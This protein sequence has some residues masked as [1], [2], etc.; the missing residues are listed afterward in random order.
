MVSES[1]LSRIPGRRKF[2]DC[3]PK[4]LGR[5]QVIGH[6][7][8][9][10]RRALSRSVAPRRTTRPLLLP[11]QSMRSTV[12]THLSPRRPVHSGGSK[13]D[14]QGQ[15]QPWHLTGH[16]RAAESLR[17]R[18]GGRP[19]V[20][21]SRVALAAW[22]GRL[23]STSYASRWTSGQT[24]IGLQSHQGLP[25]PQA[26]TPAASEW[27]QVGGAPP[28]TRRAAGQRLPRLRPSRPQAPG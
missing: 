13:A 7:G 10:Q 2:L 24:R 17:W 9:G 15:P 22:S 8:G 3:L 25:R 4:P 6:L 21:A 19:R 5:Y 18:S 28:G 14:G 11:E 20:H 1:A 27:R 26:T 23:E 16:R 12:A